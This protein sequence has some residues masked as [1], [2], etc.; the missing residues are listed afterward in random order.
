MSN[1]SCMSPRPVILDTDWWT[2]CDDVVALR[3]L[4][5]GQR[6]GLVNLRA[7]VIDTWLEYGAASLSAGC[8]DIPIGVDKHHVP[9]RLRRWPFGLGSDAGLACLSRRPGGG[10]ISRRPRDG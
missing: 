5:H 10:G 9:A 3:I 1:P 2:D 4:C 6:Q 8:S 7:I